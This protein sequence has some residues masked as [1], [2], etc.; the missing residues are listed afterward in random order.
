[1]N[2]LTSQFE[3][4][5]A[6]VKV[7]DL[8]LDASTAADLTFAVHGNPTLGE[9]FREL[10]EVQHSYIEAFKTFRQNFDYRHPDPSIAADKGR[11]GEWFKTLD[12]D[13]EAAIT[14]LSQEDID[15]K[16]IVREFWQ[17]PVGVI[18]HTYR[19]CFLIFAAK[20]AVYFRALGKPLPDQVLWWMG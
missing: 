18:F 1:M 6:S 16:I 11:L 3:L 20:A 8:L 19:E 12:A 7:R 14:V 15:G 17:A 5:N 10:G 13:I 9:L 2:S 4:L